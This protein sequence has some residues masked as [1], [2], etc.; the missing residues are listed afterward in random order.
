MVLNIS[1]QY[2]SF[3]SAQLNGSKYSYVSLT[4]WF[5]LSYLFVHSLNELLFGPTNR[6]LLGATF[7]S[8]SGPW[9]LHISQNSRDGALPSDGLTSY[10]GHSFGVGSYPFAE[11]Q[12]VY[13]IAPAN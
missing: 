9:E 13:S 6:N 2:Y 5:N 3:I 7:L 8:Q 10:L 11:M 12:L 1:I 4:I